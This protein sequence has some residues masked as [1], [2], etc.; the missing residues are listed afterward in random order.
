[1][2]IGAAS[3]HDGAGHVMWLPPG[4]ADFDP[5]LTGKRWVFSQLRPITSALRYLWAPR[6]APMLHAG[7]RQHE[8]REIL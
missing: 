8:S 2:R 5:L 1:M 7:W 3:R 4:T 6:M